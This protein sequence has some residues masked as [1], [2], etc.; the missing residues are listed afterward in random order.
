MAALTVRAR[1]AAPPEVVWERYAQPRLWPSWSPQIR[2][3]R[4]PDARIR[5]GT[6]GDVLGPLGVRV[7]F[8][9]DAVDEQARTWAWTVRTG[10]IVLRLEHTVMP[11]GAGTSTGLRMTGPRPIL[12]AYASI[13]HLALMRLVRP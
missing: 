3:V 13:A 1:G 12:L 7:H 6:K 8:V 4:T 11:S 5:P 10:P 9:V 2:G